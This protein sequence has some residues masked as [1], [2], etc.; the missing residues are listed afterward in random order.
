MPKLALFLSM[1]F[2]LILFQQSSYGFIEGDEVSTLSDFAIERTSDIISIDLPHQENPAKRFLIYGSGSLNSAYPDAEDVVYGIDS[3]SGFFS[4]GILTESEASNLKSKGY[5]VIEDFPLDFHTKY[6]STNAI[7]KISQFG[8]I[9][10][11]E[12]VHKLYNVTGNGVTVAVVDTG[13]DFSNPDI[14]ESLARDE[15]NNPIMLDADG[16]GLVLTN[17]TFAANLKYGKVYNFTKTFTLP[18]NVTSNVYESKDGVFLNTMS[19]NGTISV[20]NSLYPYYGGS[21]ILHGKITGDMKIGTSEKNFIPS[22]SGIYHLGAI[23]ASHLGKLQVVIV[24]VTDPNE[25]GVYDTITPDMSSSW[26]DFTKE[27]KSRP[28]Y[29]FDFTDETAINIGSGNEFLLYDSDDDGINDYSAGTVGA[30]VVDIYGI[31]SDKAEIDEKLGAVNGTLLPAMDENG[32]YFGIMN[33]FFGHGTATSATIASKGKMEYDIYNDT[34][35]YTILGIAPDVSIL[36]VKSLWFGD[37]FYGWMWSAGFENEENKWVDAGKP[38]ADIISNSWGVSNFPSLEYAPGLDISSH[39]LNVLVIPQL[40]H[41]NYTGTTIISSA[42]NSGHGYGTMGMP[43]ISS[44]G[45]S[46]GAVTSNDFVGYGPFK[47]EPRFGNTT[48]HSDHVVDFS[49]RG[50]GVIG[51]PK[52]D[53]MSIGAYGFVPSIIT[54]LPDEPSESFSVFGGTSMAAPIAAGSAALVV[55]SLKEKSVSYDPFMIRNLLMSSAE[56]LRNDP[57]TQGAGLVNAL[58]AVRIVNGHGGKFMVHNDA[59]FSNIKEVIDVPLSSFNSD[60]LGIDEFDLSN[61]TFPMTSW[62]GGRLNPG[63]ETTTTFTIENPNNYPIDVTI[64]P[65]TLKL[66]EKLQMSGITEPHLQDPILNE[67]ETYTPNYIKLSNI[68]AEHRIS[69][70]TSIIHPNSSLMILNLH[71][72]FDTFMNQTDTTYAD[73]LKISSLYVYDWEDKNTDDE[74]SSDELSMVS[75]GGSWGT[76][77]EIRISDPVEKFENEPVIG[78][79]PVPKIFSF[80]K[81]NTNQNSTS[82]DYTLSASYYQNVSWDDI[83]VYDEVTIL[84]NDFTDVRATLSVPSDKQTGVYQGFLSFEGKYH[85]IKSPVSY[86][87]LETV[88][89]DVKQTVISGS[90]G[91]ALYG[92]GFVKGAFDMTSRYM[93]GDWR[94]YYFDIQDHTINSATIDFEW[95][96]DDTNFTVFMIDPQGKIIQTNFPSGV[97][98][99]FL[100][101]PTSDW[102]GTS[103][104]SAGGTFYPLKNRDNTSTVLFAPI[105][106]TGTYTLLVHSTLFDGTSITEPISLAAK[107]TTIVPDEKPPEIMFEIPD[108]INKTFDILPKIIEKN[109]DFVKYYLDGEEREQEQ[110]PLRFGMLPDGQHDLRIHATDIV[111]NEAEKTFSFTIDNTPPE[112]L[113]KSPVNGTTVS[114][115]LKI[116]FK[117]KDENLAEGGAIT[118]LL[119][120][121]EFLEDVTLHS[122]NVT[123]I[124]D[125]VY[126][127]KI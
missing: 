110:L 83:T 52:P 9:A 37:V 96:N 65:E 68:P 24:L 125:G 112:I 42:G 109:P 64:K 2:L 61:K 3:D 72:P 104:F 84:P 21:H 51:D 105:N 1:F 47:G 91:G 108:L 28:N 92:N 32:N 48:D 117:V 76:V 122:F 66:I 14:M 59:T 106:Q 11:S 44:F 17:S 36:P 67:P 87:V 113:V 126:D 29:D 39:I 18:E 5:N 25:A 82:M 101:W 6:V 97:F 77:Q 53:L 71:F 27:E 69:N 80:W 7:T 120:D 10:D 78:V 90:A 33:D 94:Q 116:D 4:V 100:G 20:Y 60:L 121:G 99:E 22:K 19:K 56:D 119:P 13:V 70:E 16:Q 46:V 54:K 85:K 114:H 79:Y 102:L 15:D 34:K 88:E 31:F 43:G 89:K 81:G 86:G 40:L 127:L 118:I 115:L 74:V 75:R 55:E 38:K 12:R 45:I 57:L 41:Q 98:G 73:D 107:F 93:A 50:P 30:R 124:D 26:M 8:N 123:G 103:S 63:E 23:L 95:E 58:D 49:G 35:K 111:G 62:Y